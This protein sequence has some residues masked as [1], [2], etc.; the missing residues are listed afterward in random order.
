MSAF[1]QAFARGIDRLYSRMGDA[2][3]LTRLNESTVD[4]TVVT[5]RSLESFGTNVTDLTADSVIFSVRKTEVSE[6][7]RRGE[8]VELLDS[9]EEYVVDRM[10]D[11]TEHELTFAAT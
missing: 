9:G 10:L 4:C 8:R 7:L 1:S 2:A 5:G 11:A 6:H 3:R